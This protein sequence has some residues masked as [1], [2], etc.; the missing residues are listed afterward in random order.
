MRRVQQPAIRRRSASA[1]SGSRARFVRKVSMPCMAKARSS[2]KRSQGV[3][4]IAYR[5]SAASRAASA[6]TCATRV[7]SSMSGHGY[8]SIASSVSASLSG[9]M[10][11]YQCPSSIST[12]PLPQSSMHGRVRGPVP[13][14]SQVADG[15]ASK[16]GR[17]SVPS[18]SRIASVGRAVPSSGQ[19]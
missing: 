12:W 15:I 13:V 14:A 7:G 5:S 16:I 18:R 4:M 8:A 6:R 2:G 10:P 9:W 3:A 17:T 11:G 19:S 1:N